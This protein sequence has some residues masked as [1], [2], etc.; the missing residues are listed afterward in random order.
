MACNVPPPNSPTDHQFSL[1]ND[2]SALTLTAGSFRRS[3]HFIFINRDGVNKFAE[4][5]SC[6]VLVLGHLKLV[7]RYQGD[8]A[9][10]IRAF[11]SREWVIASG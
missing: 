7:Q 2:A 9:M 8:D 3:C 4:A 6:K 10:K 1:E 11:V 5:L